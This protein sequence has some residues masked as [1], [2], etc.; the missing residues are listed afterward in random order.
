MRTSSG[1]R[2]VRPALSPARLSLGIAASVAL[3]VAAVG[4]VLGVPVTGAPEAPVASHFV[5]VDLAPVPRTSDAAAALLAGGASADGADASDALAARVAD[6]SAENVELS[7]RVDAAEHR[8]DALTARLE[9][10]EQRADALSA[11]LDTERAR[12]AQLEADHRQEIAALESARSQLGERLAALAADREALAANL[13]AEREHREALAA[14]LA[15]ERAA[16]QA[17]LAEER[18]TYDRLLRALREQIAQ[19]DVALERAQGQ[20]TVAIVDRVLFPSGQATLTPEGARV[21]D[22]VGTALA[23]A[24]D[25]AILVEGHTDDVPI[26]AELRGRFA[27]NWELSAA[28]AAGVVERL[29]AESDLPP[30]R[31]R[32]AG[33]ADTEPVADNATEDGRRRNRR[34]EIILLPPGVLEPAS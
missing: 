5:F 1:A 33:R 2:G 27:S 16:A 13:A 29:I 17:A 3:H 7:G 4:A 20:L 26:G 23:Q 11:S 19:R 31:L 12:T 8:A 14:T 28:R 15:E 25:R 10:T 34:I 21:I 30:A 6:L 9:A 32:A 24:P 22:S 18:A